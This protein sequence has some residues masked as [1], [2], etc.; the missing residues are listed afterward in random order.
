MQSHGNTESQLHPGRYTGARALTQELSV[1][2]GQASG[3]PQRRC[4]RR[5]M[6]PQRTA[7][8]GTEMTGSA[9]FPA[10]PDWAKRASL[11]VEVA[12]LLL[13]SSNVVVRPSLPTHP[14]IPIPVPW[15]C[16]DRRIQR[17]PRL[18]LWHGPSK[19]SLQEVGLRRPPGAWLP[20]AHS[21]VLRRKAAFRRCLP[22][23]RMLGNSIRSRPLSLQTDNILSRSSS[24]TSRASQAVVRVVQE[25]CLSVELCQWHANS[26][27]CLHCR[28][29]P[30]PV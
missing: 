21:L 19:G 29:H 24:C 3:E 17:P 23:S 27:Y 25:H 20:S 9:A 4:A 18:A 11:L 22:A 12:R 7:S 2:L 1:C 13:I 5:I 30:L 6:R 8:A 15:G 10:D 26:G 28:S 14:Q 16:R